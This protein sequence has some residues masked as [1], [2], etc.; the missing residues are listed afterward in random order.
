MM[1]SDIRLLDCKYSLLANCDGK[2]TVEEVKY[3]T[4]IE[5]VMDSVVEIFE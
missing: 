3:C 4:C 5:G 1:K 2:G